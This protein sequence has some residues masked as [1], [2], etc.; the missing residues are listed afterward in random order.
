MLIETFGRPFFKYQIE[1][2]QWNHLCRVLDLPPDFEP[3]LRYVRLGDFAKKLDEALYDYVMT[4]PDEGQ[5]AFEENE[6]VN[7][8]KNRNLAGKISEWNWSNVLSSD[9]E[10]QSLVRRW[11]DENDATLDMFAVILEKPI[12]HAPATFRDYVLRWMCDEFYGSLGMARDLQIRIQHRLSV[13][14]IDRAWEDVLT[15][16]RLAERRRQTV[17][18][19]LR[20]PVPD[21]L[22]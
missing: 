2:D 18:L 11:L 7:Y 1:D 20:A 6:N 22:F 21:P 4:L 19:T 13:G 9:E 3:K 12:L 8:T 10:A 15:L 16:Y 14:E 17:S 5:W